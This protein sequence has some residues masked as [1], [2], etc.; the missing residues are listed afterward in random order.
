MKTN[1]DRSPKDVLE[2]VSFRGPTVFDTQRS[3]SE[4]PSRRSERMPTPTPPDEPGGSINSLRPL[5]CQP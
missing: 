1:D 4:S 5:H 3:V 2:R